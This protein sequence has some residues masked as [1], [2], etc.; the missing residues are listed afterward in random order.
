MRVIRRVVCQ[1]HLVHRGSHPIAFFQV[2][3]NE[4]KGSWPLCRMEI[5]WGVGPATIA[6]QIAT[7]G[8][9]TSIS[10]RRAEQSNKRVQAT[11]IFLPKALGCSHARASEWFGA[12]SFQGW[13]RKGSAGSC[14]GYHLGLQV[15]WSILSH[16]QLLVQVI[17]CRT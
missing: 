1:E 16:S 9:T 5:H 17:S 10:S 8:A 7:R 13:S 6:S 12:A 4:Q 3:A 11:R 14:W 15:T 2:S